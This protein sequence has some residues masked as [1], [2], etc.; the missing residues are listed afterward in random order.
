METNQLSDSPEQTQAIAAQLVGQLPDRAVVALHGD[1]GAGK[2]CFVKGMA[3]ALGIRDPVSSPTYT[4]I[5]EYQGERPLFHAD[6][7]RLAGGADLAS[8]GLE[9]YLDMPRGITAIEWP[10][11]AGDL[12][13]ADATHVTLELGDQPEQRRIRIVQP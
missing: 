4:L 1:L 6:L 3:I 11:R 9:E 7:Y 5:R 13:P 10:E 12:I 8:V 2:T